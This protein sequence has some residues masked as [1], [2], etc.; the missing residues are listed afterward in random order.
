M[1][2]G[3]RAACSQGEGLRLAPDRNKSLTNA[4][5][6]TGCLRW[7]FENIAVETDSFYEPLEFRQGLTRRGLD[8]LSSKED[9]TC[10]CEATA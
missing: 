10:Q 6:A 1:D 4:S 2:R 7:N 3:H 5:M 9:R 8:R